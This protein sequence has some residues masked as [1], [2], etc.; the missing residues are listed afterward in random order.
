MSLITT[1]VS[2]SKKL[3]HP[4]LSPDLTIIDSVTSFH[5]SRCFH[6]MLTFYQLR[7]RDDHFAEIATTND[8]EVS[9][10]APLSYVIKTLQNKL[11]ED[12]ES[13]WLNS[14]T[15]LRVKFFFPKPNLDINPH[16]TVTLLILNL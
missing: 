16:S 2:R 13:W 9:V 7:K 14:Y 3:N 4:A 11:V 10:P 15:G 6:L 1:A 8:V 12:W 5:L